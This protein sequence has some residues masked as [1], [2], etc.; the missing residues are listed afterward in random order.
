MF[1]FWQR[2]LSNAD[3]KG[4]F[5]VNSFHGGRSGRHIELGRNVS[6]FVTVLCVGLSVENIIH[7]IAIYLDRDNKKNFSTM[8]GGMGGVE[9]EA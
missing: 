2:H 8:R 7:S 3:L 1:D 6:I 5:I 9:S 4:L